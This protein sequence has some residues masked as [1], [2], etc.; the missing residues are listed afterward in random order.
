MRLVQPGRTL[1]SSVFFFSRSTFT[2]FVCCARYISVNRNF[3]VKPVAVGSINIFAYCSLIHFF[4]IG[5]SQFFLNPAC[6]RTS[7]ES[8]SSWKN[9]F[10]WPLNIIW[11]LHCI[12][13]L[14]EFRG[15]W[16]TSYFLDLF[17]CVKFAIIEYKGRGVRSILTMSFSFCFGI[18]VV[19]FSL[20]LLSKIELAS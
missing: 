7:Q 18:F 6:A 5:S 8:C 15:R 4:I 12:L 14:V 16:S 11:I 9:F 3:P 20:H 17:T 10:T 2:S 1:T 13:T 19:E